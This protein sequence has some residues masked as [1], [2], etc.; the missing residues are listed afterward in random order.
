[1]AM[2]IE[3]PLHRFQLIK[4]NQYVIILDFAHTSLALKESINNALNYSES[5]ERNL[6]GMV[7]GIGLR[8]LDKV[9]RTISNV[10][11]GINKLMLATEKVGYV[12]TKIIINMMRK[13]LHT[14]YKVN[15]VLKGVS[16]KEG[17]KQL[18]YATDKEKEIILLT[19]I[20]EPQNY[21]GKKYEHDDEQ[22]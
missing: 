13:H 4:I 17:I 5:I 22:Y 10:P 9:E 7:T 20:N 12:T 19:G 21:K 11:D 15:D 14:S 8:G 18:L 6:T 3:S 16:R 1:A 2:V